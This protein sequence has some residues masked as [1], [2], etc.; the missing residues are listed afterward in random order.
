MLTDLRTSLAPYIYLN[1]EVGYQNIFLSQ[2]LDN[3]QTANLAFE[4]HS[5][6]KKHDGWE[7]G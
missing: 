3:V 7:I 6:L 4:C 1:L 5:F 2:F